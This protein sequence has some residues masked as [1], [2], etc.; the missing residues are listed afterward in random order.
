M[1]IIVAV[2]FKKIKAKI[3]GR[4]GNDGTKNVEI[5]VSLRYFSNF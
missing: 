1:L 4:T 5:R 3:A 2:L